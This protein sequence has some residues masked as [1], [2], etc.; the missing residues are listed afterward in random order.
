MCKQKKDLLWIILPVRKEN[1]QWGSEE[2]TEDCEFLW[3]N[4]ENCP[5]QVCWLFYHNF[6]RKNC[7]SVKCLLFKKRLKKKYF[8]Y[9]KTSKKEFLTSRKRDSLYIV[10]VRARE[11]MLQSILFYNFSFGQFHEKCMEKSGRKNKK[12]YYFR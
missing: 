9:E 11:Y 1:T 4:H 5:V 10:E 12:S 8:S 7:I 2:R 6:S 3:K